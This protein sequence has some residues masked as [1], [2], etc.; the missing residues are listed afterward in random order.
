LLGLTGAADGPG[1][2]AHRRPRAQGHAGADEEPTEPHAG[3]G[4]ALA[5]RSRRRYRPRATAPAR[6]P[7]TSG[8]AGEVRRAG[9][10][11]LVSPASTPVSARVGRVERS[12]ATAR[13]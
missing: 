6:T 3:S 11:G 8:P 1:G 13:S 5:R 12:G 4:P 10:T 9:A 2:G 7:A